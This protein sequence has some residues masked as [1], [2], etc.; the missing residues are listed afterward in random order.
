MSSFHFTVI[1]DPFELREH[2]GPWDE[3]SA[4]AIEPNPFYEPWLLLPAVE[5]FGRGLPLSV[6][7]VYAASAGREPLLCGLFPLERVPSYKTLPLRHVRLW[8]HLH[9]FLG[10]PLLRRSHA[11]ACL[12]AFLDWLSDSRSASMMEWGRIAGD[13]PFYRALHEMLGRSGRRSF[14]SQSFERAVLRR[15]EDAE[16]YLRDSLSGASRKEF[17]RLE[18]RLSEAGALRYEALAPGGHAAPWIEEFLALEA[19][20]WKGSRGSA[21]ECSEPGRRFFTAAAAAAAR[22][23]RLMMLALRVGSRTVAMKC[24]F[25][26]QDGA[27]AFKIAYDEDYARFSP[28]TLL[29]LENVRELHRRPELRWMDSC[30]ESDHF[31]AN[32]LWLERRGI[33]SLLTATGNAGGELLVSSMP[34]LRRVTAGL[35]AAPQPT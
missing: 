8:R 3:L 17:R 15:R 28:G 18:R 26:A 27:F 16:S 14:V 2:V 4:C 30:A 10:T 21:L 23:G 35:R 1:E 29:E 34:L 25:L 13:G 33:V 6:V 9:C 31:M 32:R 19:R 5:A 7:L 12:E 22:R 24:N 11:H 20:G